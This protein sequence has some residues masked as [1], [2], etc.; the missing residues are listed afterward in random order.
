MRRT[1]ALLCLLLFGCASMPPERKWEI[2]AGGGILADAAVSHGQFEANPVYGRRG[3]AG[4]ILAL[5]SAL[6]ALIRASLRGQ[7]ETWRIRSWQVVVAVRVVVLAWNLSQ[8]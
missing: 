4:E 5:N 7:P 6:H 3:D 8:R 2:A 1:A